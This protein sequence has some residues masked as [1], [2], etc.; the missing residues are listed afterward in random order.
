[1]QEYGFVIAIGLVL[2]FALASVIFVKRY[3]KEKK[4]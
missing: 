3:T 1:M 2:L 4:T